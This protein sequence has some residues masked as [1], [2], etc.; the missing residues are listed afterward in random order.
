MDIE[1]ICINCKFREK[2]NHCISGKFKQGMRNFSS[3]RDRLHFSYDESG[4][5]YVEDNF[6]CIHFQAVTIKDFKKLIPYKLN[7]EE[8]KDKPCNQGK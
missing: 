6:G 1:R 5:F 7:K 4:W 8:G 3:D 2:N